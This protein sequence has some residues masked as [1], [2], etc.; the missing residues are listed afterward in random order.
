MAAQPKTIVPMSKRQY[1]MIPVDQIRVLN[2]RT[3]DK[4]QFEEN[5]R[6]IGS[7]GLL[8]PIVVN[9]RYLS[10][11]GC[12]QLVCGEGRFIAYRQLKRDKIPAEIVNCDRKTALL[13]SLVENLARV[14]PNTMWFA[15]EL[16]RMKDC[17]LA[18]AKIAEIAGKNESYIVDYIRLVELGEERLIKGVEVGLF[19]I[20]FATIVAKS[21]TETIQNVLMDA[22][23]TG[24][25]NSK[26]AITV[27]N[28]VE[29][30]ISENKQLRAKQ[31][32]RTPSYSIAHL[33]SDISKATEH[34][35]GFVREAATKENR[36]L[37]LLDG[38]ETLDRDKALRLILEEEG[39]AEQPR[40]AG[41]YTGVSRREEEEEA[42]ADGVQD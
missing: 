29:H 22:F 19:P 35:E 9:E 23:D 28:L 25:I 24:I 15:R 7:I 16:K 14:P 2:S 41:K 17:G 31:R 37:A 32:T 33:Q 27:R 6:S 38:L 36:V 39:L 40:L 13:F 42:D 5:I 20:S 10:N 26:N 21:S 12:Y 3:R 34:K 11:S 30:R 1:K 4:A 18:T 8:K